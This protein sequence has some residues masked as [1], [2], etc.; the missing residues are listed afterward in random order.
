MR[1]LFFA[2][3]LLTGFAASGYAAD[4]T[5]AATI[6]YSAAPWDGAAYEIDIPLDATAEAKH[7]MIRVNIWGH[8]QYAKPTTL[9]F[10]GRE[11]AG[12]GP[13]RGSGR[14]SYQPVFD[15]SLPQPLAGTL[16]FDVLQKDKPVSGKYDLVTSD[17]KQAFKGSF[18]AKWGNTLPV[19]GG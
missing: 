3:V 16:T 15:Q 4:A 9:R 19:P 14:V 12:G 8:P 2:L 7:P 17:G 11:N 6:F 18:R 10:F 5:R 13:D 1:R